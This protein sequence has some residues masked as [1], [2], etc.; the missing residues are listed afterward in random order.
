MSPWLF[1][2]LAA[3]VTATMAAVDIAHARYALA[4]VEVRRFQERG[5]PWRRALYHAAAWSVIQWGAAGV[6]LVVTMR[7]SLWFLPFE[8]LGLFVGTLIGGSRKPS[9]GLERA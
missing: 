1:A 9:Q 6:A 5:L 3:L 7:V 4:M 8:A 2:V